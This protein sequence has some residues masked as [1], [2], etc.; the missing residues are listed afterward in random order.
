[1]AG[2]PHPSGSD[3]AGPGY[4]EMAVRASALFPFAVQG[5]KGDDVKNEKTVKTKDMR[6]NNRPT[7]DIDRSVNG[8]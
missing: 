2:P 6:S 7:Q 3:T 1:M 8:V 4:L 5:V